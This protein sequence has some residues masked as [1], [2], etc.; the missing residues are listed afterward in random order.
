MGGELS[1]A[2]VW[3][4]SR[5][6]P[7]DHPLWD[8]TLDGLVAL[9]ALEPLDPTFEKYGNFVLPQEDGSVLVWGGFWVVSYVFRYRGDQAEFA[10]VVAAIHANQQTSTYKLAKR[11]F[12]KREKDRAERSRLMMEAAR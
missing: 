4:E 9:L 3:M 2:A 11:D 7:E 1:V 8:K 12:R 10:H 5:T 6:Y